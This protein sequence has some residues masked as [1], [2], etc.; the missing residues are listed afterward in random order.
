VDS[1]IEIQIDGRPDFDHGED[2]MQKIQ[3]ET[4][5]LTNNIISILTKQEKK[6]ISVQK[7]V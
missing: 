7:N 3:N 5:R 4:I 6:Y 2:L 1:I